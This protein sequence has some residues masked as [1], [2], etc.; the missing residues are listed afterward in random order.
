MAVS[1]GIHSA[2]F[3]GIRWAAAIALTLALEHAEHV[4]GLILIGA[5]ARL[6]WGASYWKMLQ[7]T[8]FR[9]R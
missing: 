2:V 5:G 1:P 3:A 8:T 9:M 6:R 7:P 4:N